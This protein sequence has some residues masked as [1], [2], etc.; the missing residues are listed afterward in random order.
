MAVEDLKRNAMMAH[1]LD[2]PDHK[3]DISYYGRLVNSLGH[4]YLSSHAKESRY[5][6]PTCARIAVTLWQSVSKFW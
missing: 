2:A 3:K 6:V 1:L 5:L 4:A